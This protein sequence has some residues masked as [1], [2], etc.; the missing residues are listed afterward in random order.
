MKH[1][2]FT[3]ELDVTLERGA[4]VGVEAATDVHWGKNTG[5]SGQV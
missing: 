2:L 3:R 1:L 5:H 4:A